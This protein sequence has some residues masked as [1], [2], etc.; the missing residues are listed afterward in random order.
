MSVDYGVTFACY[1]QWDYTKQCLNSLFAS[2][3]TPERV[4]VVDNCSTDGTTR[5][6]EQFKLR[7]VVKNSANWGCGVAWNQGITELQTE[8]I[9][10]MNNDVV[11]SAD[12]VRT[13][14]DASCRAGLKIASPPIV[15]GDC[16]ATS[17]GY[18]ERSAADAN[19]RNHVRRGLAHGVAMLIHTSVFK[20]IG[21]FRPEPRMM[22]FEDTLFFHEALRAGIPIGTVGTG[23]LH[24][25]GSITQM[26]LKA[27][28]GLSSKEGLGM[29]D[30]HRT[31]GLSWFGRKLKKAE[32]LRLESRYRSEELSKFGLTLNSWQMTGKPIVWL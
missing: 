4:V 1:N 11:V 18:A 17:I 21:L 6:L 2:G 15:N 10:V 25:F 23:W 22:G 26:A 30:A 28:R 19:L 27:E 16:P 8:W 9:V 3:V 14:I 20:Q 7:R 29:R 13:L 24:H 5:E 31:L 32:K 12:W